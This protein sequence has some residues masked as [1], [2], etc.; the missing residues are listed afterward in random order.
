MMKG[1]DIERMMDLL[2]GEERN[3]QEI[4]GERPETDPSWKELE[5]IARMLRQEPAVEPPGS[6]GERVMERIRAHR[7]SPW[8]VAGEALLRPRTASVDP[9]RALRSPVSGQE[10]S[11]YFIMVGVFYAILG[12]VLM[13]GLHKPGSTLA[14]EDWVHWQLQIALVTASCMVAIGLCLL[15][16]GKPALRIARIGAFVYLGIALLNGIA[17]PLERGLPVSA[18]LSLLSTLIGVPTGLFLIRTIQNCGKCYAQT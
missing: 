1:S 4:A 13:I 2:T 3:P 14:P 8:T 6:L 15:K 17:V 9:F 5:A 18:A 16:D 10:C 11:F 7:P 12:V